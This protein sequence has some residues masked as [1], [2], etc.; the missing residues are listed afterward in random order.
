MIPFSPANLLTPDN[1]TLNNVDISIMQM[2]N[3]HEIYMYEGEESLKICF[4]QFTTNCSFF[5]VSFMCSA[6]G[7]SIIMK[8]IYIYIYIH[9]IYIYIYI[10]IM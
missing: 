3:L 1:K 10:Y 9:V 8:H 5:Y 4:L 2:C 6:A 7:S